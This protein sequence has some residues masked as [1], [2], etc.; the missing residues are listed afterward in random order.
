M[1]TRKEQTVYKNRG[2]ELG[3]EIDIFPLD[4][5]DDDIDIGMPRRDYEKFIKIASE[6][7]SSNF[8]LVSY[9]NDKKYQ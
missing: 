9:R 3:V 1:T 6:C 7:L 4:T 2:V 5:W 8:K